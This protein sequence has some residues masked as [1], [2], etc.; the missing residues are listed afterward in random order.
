[1]LCCRPFGDADLRST[2]A[3]NDSPPRRAELVGACARESPGG[4]L[5]PAPGV[6]GRCCDSALGA[7]ASERHILE[8]KLG[9]Y[10]SIYRTTVGEL[11]EA[12]FGLLATFQPPHF[13]VM[14][15]GLVS[16]GLG[17]RARSAVDEPLRGGRTEE[18]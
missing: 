11:V 4:L 14:L 9:T 6:Y 8:R 16:R 12:G 13:T 10:E 3:G 2:T 1:M 5:R 18:R 7:I 17:R 15:P